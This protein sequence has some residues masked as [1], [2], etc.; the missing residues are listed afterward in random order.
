MPENVVNR[1]A[2]TPSGNQFSPESPETA[3]CEWLQTSDGVQHFTRAW[4]AGQSGP[5][6]FYLHG[7]EGH[8]RWFEETAL[9][10]NERGISVYALDRR[11]AGASKEHRGHIGDYRRMVKDV[12]ELIE[13]VRSRHPGSAV[14]LVGN[15]WGAKVAVT[16]A[17]Q[18]Q[19]TGTVQA[20]VLTSPAVAVQVDVTPMT[21]LQIGL[22]FLFGTKKY[23]D[24]PLT[25]E[26]FT[27]NPI[28]LE[29][30]ASDRLRLKQA[31]ASFFVNSLMLTRACKR[32][33]RL[34]SMP[35]LVLQ[36][37]RDE[38]VRVQSIKQW[39]D[40]ISSSDKTLKIF[41]SA[42]HSLDFDAAAPEYQQTLSN[43]ITDRV[44]Q[45]RAADSEPSN[46]NRSRLQP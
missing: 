30:I 17:A 38:I 20:L 33:G 44:K 23:F 41:T 43:W 14:V 9:A 25:P 32:A 16:V 5:V 13:V 4:L 35:V 12:E 36:S 37:G 34:L 7:I 1:S 31:T 39:F 19:K 24:I 18:A 26:H 8:S 2:Q 3:R 28:Y 11:G 46:K 27:D 10:L 6:C 21:K 40:T 42:A 22:N 29:Y 45:L 15:C